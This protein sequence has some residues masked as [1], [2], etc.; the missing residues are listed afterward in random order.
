MRGTIELKTDRL[1]LRRESLK[2]ADVMH[3]L[4]GCDPEITK[5]TGWNPYISRE[6]TLEKIGFDIK[7]YEKEG[8]YSW[9]I[10]CDGDFVGTIGAYDYDAQKSQIEIGYS[11]VRKFWGRGFA[12]EAAA[13]V[14]EFLTEEGIKNIIAWG[15]FENMASVRILENLGFTEFDRDDK[16]IYYARKASDN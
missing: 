9:V 6:S 10:V 14:V 5:Y 13:K 12:S 16:Q 3:K 1:V 15:H 11:I 4:L 2:D 7:G 8:C